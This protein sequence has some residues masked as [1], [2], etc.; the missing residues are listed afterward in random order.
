MSVH[1]R[2]ERRVVAFAYD[3]ACVETELA[4]GSRD[5]LEWSEMCAHGDGSAVTLEE[6][7]RRVLHDHPIERSYASSPKEE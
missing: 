1:H 5:E 7:L 4:H 6:P 3:D 2:V